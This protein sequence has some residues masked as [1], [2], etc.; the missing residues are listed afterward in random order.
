MDNTMIGKL[1]TM[2]MEVWEVRSILTIF[3]VELY[4]VEVRRLQQVVNVEIYSSLDR[5]GQC[6]NVTHFTFTYL[7]NKF[8][9]I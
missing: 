4:V 8:L 5:L 3:A 9:T 7:S 2:T 1:P 6:A